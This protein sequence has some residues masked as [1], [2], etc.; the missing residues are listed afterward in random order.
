MNNKNYIGNKI[1]IKKYLE[2]NLSKY[3]EKDFKKNNI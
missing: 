1:N 3:F 2:D